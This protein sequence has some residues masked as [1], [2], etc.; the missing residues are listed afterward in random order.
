LAIN[1]KNESALSNKGI[2][3]DDLGNYNGAILYYDKALAIN[4]G[5][6]DVL[7][8]KGNALYDLGNYN[9]AILY[10]D[11]ALAINPKYEDALYNKGLALDSLGNY[12]GAIEFYNKT[13]AID[14][15]NTFALT[16]K[17]AILHMLGNNTTPGNA[18][19]FLEYENS[20]YGIKMQYPSN[21][22]VEGASNSSIVASFYPQRNNAGYVMVDIQNL[23]TNYTP[24]QYLNSLILGDSADYK[25][26]PDIRFNQNTTNNIILAG[27]PGYLLNGT[28]RDPSSDTLQRFTNIG[29]I[30]GDKLYSIIYYSPAE[31]Y[32][33][34]NTIYDQ[35]IKSFEVI[36][37]ISSG[38]NEVS[39]YQNR[40][41]GIL[42]QYPS[43][44]SEQESKSSGELINV[45]KF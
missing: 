5:E 7:Y 23:T 42:I 41:Y 33:V 2:A 29:T 4:P 18:T 14:P 39:T 26:F 31:T 25:G 20:T 3:L 37:Q 15:K 28:F 27:H 43:D 12:T 34:Y 35:M 10:Y 32:P 1:P 21:W 24:G 38:Q 9:G 22:R 45:A 6:A 36:P 30:I 19:N 8:N 16:N 17:D 13:L 11:K 40:N 44:W